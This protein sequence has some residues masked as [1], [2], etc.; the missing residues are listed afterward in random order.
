MRALAVRFALLLAFVVGLAAP[1]WAAAPSFP[2]LSG[3]V[4]DEAGVLS[5]GTRQTL[6]DALSSVIL[7]TKVL[8]RFKAGDIEG[9]V[10]DGTDAIVLG[11]G[12]DAP[13]ATELVAVV[14]DLLALQ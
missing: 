14:L 10:K 8:P 12:P 3:R 7:Q 1:A 11:L 13:G 5:A 9:G 4:V 2:A 6:T